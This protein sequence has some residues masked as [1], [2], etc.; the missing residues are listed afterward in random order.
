MTDPFGFDKALKAFQS[1]QAISGKEGV[2]APLL[3]K[4]TEG[5]LEAELES[6]IADDV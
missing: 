4:L 6:R 1:G 5:A 2:L 3:K